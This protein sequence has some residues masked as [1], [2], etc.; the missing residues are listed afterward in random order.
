[1][2]VLKYVG[3]LRSNTHGASII[4]A[5]VTKN[6]YWMTNGNGFFMFKSGTNISTSG[7]WTGSYAPPNHGDPWQY[8]PGTDK[9]FYTNSWENNIRRKNTTGSNE[10]SVNVGNT[11]RGIIVD[12]EDNNY[13]YFLRGNYTHVYKIKVDF[14]GSYIFVGIIPNASSY[15]SSHWGDRS[16]IKI[17]NSIYFA[18]STGIDKYDIGGGVKTNY[19]SHSIGGHNCGLKLSLKPSNLSSTNKFFATRANYSNNHIY[20]YSIGTAPN[21]PNNLNPTGSNTTPEL[22]DSL[23][24]TISWTFSDPDTG[25]TQGKYQ[26]N[27]H[28]AADNSLVKNTGVVS[29][30]TTSYKVPTGILQPNTK[31][32]WKVKVWDNAGNDSSFSTN[33]YFQ[34]TQVPTVIPTSPLG[35]SEKPKGTNETPRLEWEYDDP[36]SHTQAY[37]QIVIKDKSDN[38]VHDTEK[39]SNTQPHYDV[40]DKT[41]TPGEIYSWT[42]KVWDNSDMPST[43]TK[44]Q[45]FITNLPPE[46]PSNPGPADNYRVPLKPTLEF[47]A[48]TDAENENIH[49]KLELASDDAFTDPTV[50][51]SS[52]DTTGWEYYNET[53]W[54]ALSSEGLAFEDHGKKIRY[55]FQEDLTEGDT[56][57]WQVAGYNPNIGKMGEYSDAQRIRV[58]NSIVYVDEPQ[59]TTAR[60]ERILGKVF[61]NLATDGTAP[62]SWKLEVC[63]NALDENPTWEEITQAVKDGAYH[64]FTNDT[65]TATEWAVNYK[66]TVEANDTM[67]PI[68]VQAVSISFD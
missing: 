64:V 1:M 33:Q 38:V 31:Y 34:T 35:I 51:D 58:G 63:N 2:A 65:K 36:E 22:M 67:G 55:T 66:F 60:A 47:T 68:E 57:Y 49:F 7:G 17:G 52:T 29:S 45:Y 42:V 20:F 5:T 11:V 25:D 24:P 3:G 18:D 50:K 46:K 9:V 59:A 41:L 56:Y 27:I 61:L 48:P 10:A 53:T 23:T 32:Y 14:S 40:P 26:V 39:I 15:T 8:H 44:E 13:I 6:K 21:T 19:V 37:S 28:K 4:T 43:E 30:S 12:P 16:G 62:A 54:K